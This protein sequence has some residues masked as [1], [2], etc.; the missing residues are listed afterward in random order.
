MMVGLIQEVSIFK[1]KV[2]KKVKKNKTKNK[3]QKTKNKKQKTKNKK[4]K[5]KNKKQNL[6]INTTTHKIPPRN[7]NTSPIPP[8]LPMIRG[9]PICYV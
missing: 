4:Q 5:T 1:K 7:E 2:N 9:H 3:K 8:T 6:Q